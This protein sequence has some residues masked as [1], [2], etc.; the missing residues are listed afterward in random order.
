MKFTAGGIVF[1]VIAWGVIL[2]A[3]LFSMIKVLRAK[4]GPGGDAHE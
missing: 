1:M 2:A 4:Q 3:A